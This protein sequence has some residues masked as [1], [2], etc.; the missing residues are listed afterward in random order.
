MATNREEGQ[1]RM[2]NGLQLQ[3]IAMS[4][5]A[6]VV[7]AGSGCSDG[8]ASIKDSVRPNASTKHASVT[9]NASGFE[10][11][12]SLPVPPEGGATT[13]ATIGTFGGTELRALTTM[14]GSLYAGVGYWEDTQLDNPALPGAQIYRLD[15]ANGNWQVD[16]ELDDVTP[17]GQPRAGRRVFNT[18]DALETV[19][20]ERDGTGSSIGAHTLL[21]ASVL[22]TGPRVT[23]LT[24]ELGKSAWTRTVLA[25]VRHPGS[26]DFSGDLRSFTR[27]RDKVTGA[28]LVLAGV[29]GDGIYAATYDA[30]GEALVFGKT[31]EPG[32][33]G[34]ANV[35]NRFT[36]F[37]ES[38]GKLYTT[39]GS[40]VFERQDGPSPRWVQVFSWS[41]PYTPGLSGFRGLTTI[42]NRG[43][44]GEDL[45]VAFNGT[46]RT[47]VLR[48]VPG[49]AFTG[50]VELHVRAFYA[51]ALGLQNP[52]AGGLIDYND[53]LSY[54]RG[55]SS[56]P[57]LLIG[58]Q[59]S[60]KHCYVLARRCDG[61]AYALHEV[62]DTSISP[63]PSLVAVRTL[64]NSP[65]GA[66]PPGTVYAGG[67]DADGKPAHNTAWLYKGI[68]ST[69]GTPWIAISNP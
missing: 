6:L 3:W 43:G 21:L 55:S 64:I 61:Q 16:L 23:V 46:M 68:P 5:L 28:D 56:C 58:T 30:R 63:A 67:Y 29:S 37:A 54:Q 12:L 52:P 26:N 59:F 41:Q 65:F 22:T 49:S 42:P 38:N 45:L 8:F 13:T 60:K 48:I 17:A 1:R 27:Y 14:G 53:M 24:K 10:W 47:E 44:T 11:Q 33:G 31:P 35:S 32:V 69:T 20:L 25:S 57:E 7:G 19:T 15:A 66:D 34:T 36:S 51:R 62:R 50:D 18:V 40:L 9:E 39:I 4:A 2:Q